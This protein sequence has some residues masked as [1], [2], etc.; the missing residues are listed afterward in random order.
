MTRARILS[1]DWREQPDFGTLA[2][3]VSTMSDGGVHVIQADTGSDQYAL[4]FTADGCLDEA[5]TTELY[6]EWLHSDAG[7]G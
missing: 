3:I 4:V 6:H 1:W 5:A 7:R 2:D